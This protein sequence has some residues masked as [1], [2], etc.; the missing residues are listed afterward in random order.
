MIPTGAA[1]PVQPGEA[2]GRDCL[3][4]LLFVPQIA[5]ASTHLC[6]PA[7]QGVIQSLH[8][9]RALGKQHAAPP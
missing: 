7:A 3:W 4:L 9:W 1:S 8:V 2:A 5:A 6:Q